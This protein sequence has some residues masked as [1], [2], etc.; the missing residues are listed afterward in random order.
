LG[1][2]K[3]AVD[4]CDGIIIGDETIDPELEAYIRM[5][6]K[7]VLEFQPRETYVDAYNAFYDEILVKESILSE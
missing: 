2:A 3:P 7:P 4:Y 5:S 1:S 6:E